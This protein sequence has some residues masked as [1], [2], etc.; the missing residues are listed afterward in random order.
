MAAIGIACTLLVMMTFL[1][2]ALALAGRWVFWPRLPHRRPAR[3]DLA[4]ARH[5]G[6]D[7]PVRRRPRPPRPGSAP[8]S[9]LL[10]RACS[11]IGGAEDRRPDHRAGLHQHPGRRASGQQIYDAKFDQ[12]VG[13]PAVIV[14]NADAGRRR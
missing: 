2:V 9:L 13:A 7:R 3:A 11:G 14:A 10:A 5:L 12:G 1:P 4:T 8:P 6:P